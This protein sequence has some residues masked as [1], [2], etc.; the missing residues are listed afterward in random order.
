[1]MVFLQTHGKVLVGF[2]SEETSIEFI[3]RAK[4]IESRNRHIP[5]DDIGIQYEDDVEEVEDDL[6]N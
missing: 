3:E 2:R 4:R 5:L 6:D 1:M